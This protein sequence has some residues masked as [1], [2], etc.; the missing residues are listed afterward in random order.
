MDVVPARENGGVTSK[1]PFLLYAPPEAQ[2]QVHLV[3]GVGE[4]GARLLA[5]SRF[6]IRSVQDLLQHYPRRHLD[7]SETKTLGEL[8]IG[9]EVTVIA[10]VRRAIPP[11]HKRPRLPTKIVVYDGT[12]TLSLVF[13][14][15]PWRAKQLRV[16]T[17]VAA[18]GKVSSFRGVRQMNSPLVDVIKDPEEAVRI[19]PLYPATAEIHTAW[20]RKI[21]KAAIDD[22]SPLADPLPLAARDRHHLL[23][24][25]EALATYHF[26]DQMPEMW[27]AR[28][29]LVFDE[30][31]TLQ[32]GLAYRKH[33]IEE[34][35]AGIAHKTEGNL[36]ARFLASLPFELTSAQKKA[37]EEVEADMARPIPMHRL[38]QG[39][40]GSG[41]AQP[42]HTPVLT[43]AGFK[44]MGEIQVGDEL[45][46][47]TG[48]ITV[49]TGVFPQ[50]YRH[51]WRLVFSDETS[52]ECDDEHLWAVKTSA[53]WYR[54]DS[55]KL[56]TTCEIRNDLT[57]K[58]GSS[59]WYVPA[60]SAADLEC[61]DERP[62]DP[63]LLGVLLGDGTFRANIGLS[64]ADQEIVDSVSE[65]LPEGCY[66]KREKSRRYD[67][68]VQCKPRSN[69][70]RPHPVAKALK[71]LGLRG[72]SSHDKYVPQ[73]YLVA[74]IKVRHA[75]LQGLLDTDGTIDSKRGSDISFL[76][77]SQQLALDVQWLVQS[78]GGLARM[79]PVT[80]VGKRYFR[81]SVRLP[82]AYSAF[83]LTRKAKLHR[84]LTRYHSFRR[85]IRRV[86]YVGREQVQCISVAH[87][88][89]LYVTDH[90]VPT[91]NTVVALHAALMAVDGGFQAA[92]MA[93]TEVLAGQHFLT[94]TNLLGRSDSQDLPA[95]S[96]EGQ[97]GL[98][99]GP[100]VVLLTG[101]VGAARRR[102]AIQKIANGSAGII[103][104]THA[105]IQEGVGFA[106]LGLAVVDEQHRFGVHQ[107][108]LLR[109]KA[110]GTTPDVLVMTATPI[111][112]TLALT[113]YGDLD[114]SV[115][116]ELPKGRQPVSTK[117]I[118]ET[119]RE[120]A[121]DLVREEAAAGRQAFVIVPLVEESD[122]LEVKSAEAEAERLAAEVFPDLSVGK[123]HGRMR[124]AE[125]ENVMRRFRSG[126]IDILISTT[127]IEVGVDVPNATAMLIEDADRFGLSQ[128]HQLRGRI[129]RGE[130]PS[131]CLLMTGVM[132]L[133]EEERMEARARLE[134]VAS[135]GDGF[136]LAERDLEIRGPGEFMGA[137]QAGWSD[138]RL[139]NPVR[140]VEILKEARDEAFRLIE[141]DP[142]LAEHP[143]IRQEMEGRFA[144]RL[145]WLF[146]S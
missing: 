111:P 134:A 79:R 17:M 80:K 53:G 14:N 89:Q 77:A 12:S 78:L 143:L 6:S 138:L 124:P 88:N 41:K 98:F 62:L 117:V 126:E 137:R 94:I 63:Y 99:E 18:K 76:S 35:T 52:V 46:N 40:V 110:G 115:L 84:S 95:A 37:V 26:P 105:L 49:V 10:E 65:V 33:R 96:G 70:Y 25:T 30:L 21:I 107:R 133:P 142:E 44:P 104:G 119:S 109:E 59:K 81:V 140:D 66:L 127:V 122:K 114:V 86:E 8:R 34:S 48:E 54:G 121:Y 131:T 51:V 100:E 101:G 2:I 60:I 90:F 73:A 128:L 42:L 125:K 91:H 31:F 68:L 113:L 108:I 61:G 118:D 45:V 1:T 144:D 57:K 93:P 71:Q 3:K 75:V 136:E 82:N 27:T 120:K 67:Y 83:R 74:P 146:H 135:T 112:R 24:R 50:G 87:P 64:T 92:I 9:D 22:Y 129:G 16:G 39:E 43:P 20:L 132:D 36:A 85:A 23:D 56:K 130:H 28:R 29:R 123:L 145:D 58:N 139:T 106:N 55:I 38:L 69:Q 47:P 103:V 116:D 141:A 11:P 13:F 72:R 97:L 32:T 15:Q 7:F 19:V 4:K 5:E 102:A